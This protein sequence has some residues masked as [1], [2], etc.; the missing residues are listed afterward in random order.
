ME[1]LHILKEIFFPFIILLLNSLAQLIKAYQ[2][3]SLQFSS[4]KL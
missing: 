2:G 3:N 4:F 1:H